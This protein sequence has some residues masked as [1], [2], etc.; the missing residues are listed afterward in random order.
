MDSIID[1]FFVQPCFD[2]DTKLDFENEDWLAGVGKVSPLILSEYSGSSYNR[3]ELYMECKL[4]Y[5]LLWPKRDYLLR[6]V[7]IRNAL[8][9]ILAEILFWLSDIDG[10]LHFLH[11]LNSFVSGSDVKLTKIIEIVEA[12]KGRNETEEIKLQDV[13]EDED[14]HPIFQ[15]SHPYACPLMTEKTDELRLVATKWIACKNELGE[16]RA[17]NMFTRN[18][19]VTTNELE[20][21]FQIEE[22]AWYRLVQRGFHDNMVT[23]IA[24]CSK[25]QNAER[26]IKVLQN[27]NTYIDLISHVCDNYDSYSEKF[28]SNMHATLM[29]GENFESEEEDGVVIAVALI[30][31]GK[32]FYCLRT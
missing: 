20:H 28:I 9:L 14:G 13:M 1:S 32:A 3:A 11:L 29:E 27:T 19:C 26:I 25:I 24:E 21:V 2:I 12:L 23:G 7:N 10:S 8:C 6:I 30:P 4:R 15:L 31:A 22:S 17:V 16:S 5:N 18:V